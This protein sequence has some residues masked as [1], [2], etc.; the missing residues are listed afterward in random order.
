MNPPRMCTCSQSWIPLPPPFP[1][2]LSGSSL[3]TSPKHPVSCIEPRLVICFLY[4][5]IHASMPFSQIIPPSPSPTESK[6]LLYTSVSL[7]LSHIQSYHSLIIRLCAGADRETMRE[8][9]EFVS[10]ISRG[11]SE[12]VLLP[13]Q[14]RKEFKIGDMSLST[15]LVFGGEVILRDHHWVVLRARWPCSNNN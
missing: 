7:L 1:Y 10:R 6:R 2:H 3:C 12:H 8:E 4:G 13:F 9:D 14:S 5:I 11:S 15:Q